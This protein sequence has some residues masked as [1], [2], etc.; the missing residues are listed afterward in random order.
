MKIKIKLDEGATMP[1]RATSGSVGYDVTAL[2]VR[3]LGCFDGD[4]Y[5]TKENIKQQCDQYKHFSV[6]CGGLGKARLHTYKLIIDTGVHVQPED[7]YYVELV[8]N[9]RLAKL[10]LIYGNS[11]GVI[12]PDYTGSIKCVLDVLDTAV[13]EHLEHFLP[14]NVVGQL[15]IRKKY[16]A[17]FIQVDELDET[18]RGDGGF[19][20]TACLAQNA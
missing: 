7:G 18:D 1:T 17:G 20:S 8:P 3:A 12:D 13:F 9:S 15:I 2:R 19:G 11:I 16:D 14:G 5:L 4:A 6:G 10:G